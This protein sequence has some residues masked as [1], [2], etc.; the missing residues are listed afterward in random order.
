MQVPSVLNANVHTMKVVRRKKLSLERLQFAPVDATSGDSGS[1]SAASLLCGQPANAPSK[2]DF[3]AVL[4]SHLSS[5]GSY[6]RQQDCLVVHNEIQS[7]GY[8]LYCRYMITALES[9]VQQKR[10]ALSGKDCCYSI[11][12]SFTKT[13]SWTRFS[14]N[15]N[16]RSRLTL[17]CAAGTQS[18]PK[19]A[20]QLAYI[21][22]TGCKSE[23]SYPPRTSYCNFSFSRNVG[24]LSGIRDCLQVHGFLTSSV[25]S[26]RFW[27]CMLFVCSRLT[28]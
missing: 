16:W 7:P 4:G 22:K 25:R 18:K 10:Y 23:P 3:W 20:V 27:D 28:R 13:D 11:C 5:L 12:M 15:C 17:R 9:G 21:F 8:N 1:G 26:Q 6:D 14:S 19:G 2:Y 24:R